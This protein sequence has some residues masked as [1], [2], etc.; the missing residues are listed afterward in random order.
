MKRRID[1]GVRNIVRGS[2]PFIGGL[3]LLLGAAPL[4]AQVGVL[5]QHLLFRGEYRRNQS[6]GWWAA[7]IGD[8]N[9]DGWRDFAVLF[10]G[11]R[12]SK[13]HYGVSVRSGRD[14]RVLWEKTYS[15]QA[16][17]LQ[18]GLT[19]VGDMNGDGIP[20]LAVGFQ[21]LLSSVA[22]NVDF[23]SGKDGTL[24][25]G[26]YPPG[27]VP[28]FGGALCVLRGPKGKPYLFVVGSP[29]EITQSK[30]KFMRGT[31]RTYDYATL[32]LRNTFK[33]LKTDDRYGW[34]VENL[35]DVDGDGYDDL[36][37]GAP[38]GGADGY[39]EVRSGRSGK[40]LFS[41]PGRRDFSGS[42]FGFRIAAVGDVD[43]DG[44]PD[45]LVGAPRAPD[46]RK[47]QIKYGVGY[48]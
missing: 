43:R 12:V 9:Q 18:E 2:I 37:I 39:V 8:L 1:L 42:S 13:T 27:T 30:P 25:R 23:L 19:E 16:W 31:V 6:L 24:I 22:G 32:K 41:I 44:V 20:D 36:A 11:N 17:V 46:F 14:G 21:G 29:M 5:K 3:I 34:A 35:G 33:G 7:G 48:A 15:H 26:L 28:E 45:M 10:Y 38:Y 47:F 4:S 40:L